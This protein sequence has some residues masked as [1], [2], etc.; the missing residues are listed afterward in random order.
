MESSLGVT[1]VFEEFNCLYFWMIRR[2]LSWLVHEA[3]AA[4]DR[5]IALVPGGSEEWLKELRANYFRSV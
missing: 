1:S 4:D 3:R 2:Y 5:A